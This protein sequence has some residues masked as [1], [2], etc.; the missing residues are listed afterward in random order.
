MIIPAIKI[1][2][3]RAF[4]IQIDSPVQSAELKSLKCNR[5]ATNGFPSCF[6][7]L[8]YLSIVVVL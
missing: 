7:L 6:Y 5:E 4:T 1:A 8:L 3:D 2:I